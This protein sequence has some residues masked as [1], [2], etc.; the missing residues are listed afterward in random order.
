MKKTQKIILLGLGGQGVLFAGKLLAH[1]AFLDGYYSTFMPTYG[2]EVQNGP[3]KAEVIISK[4]E[5]IFN[6]FIDKADYIMVFHKFRFQES[7]DL[8]DNKGT[9]FCKDFKADSTGNYKL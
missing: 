7:K 9:I 5:E 4:E 8:I 1:S 6:P 3:V 2:P